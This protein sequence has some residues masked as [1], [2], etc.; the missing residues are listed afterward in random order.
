M[1]FRLRN[2]EET[3]NICRSMKKS[4][5]FQMLSAI[6]YTIESL[7]EVQI[8]ERPCVKALAVVIMNFNSDGIKE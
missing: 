3:F 1:K 6:N 5:E 8:E 4:R 7:L 2:E